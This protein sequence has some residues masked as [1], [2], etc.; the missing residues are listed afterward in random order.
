MNRYTLLLTALMIL[1]LAGFA[2]AGTAEEIN[3]AIAENGYDWVA[4]DNEVAKLNREL[5]W[6]QS[7]TMESV[8]F[9]GMFAP[10]IPIES[11]EGLPPAFDWRNVDGDNFVTSIKNQGSCGSCWA[12]ATTGPMETAIAYAEGWVDPRVDLSEQQLVSCSTAGSCESGGLTTS[13]FRFAEN[14]GIAREECFP[15]KASDNFA[16][17]EICSDWHDQV[18]KIDAWELVSVTGF[19]IDDIKAAVLQA[20]VAGSLVIYEDLFYY[21]SGV[22]QNTKWIPQGLHAVT[23]IGWDDALECWIAKNS[24][25]GS[26]GDNGIF[27]IKWGNSLI[28]SMSIMPT[29]YTQNLGPEPEEGDDDDEP[30]TDDDDDDDAVQEPDSEDNGDD[31]DD[32]DDDD[33]G[34]CG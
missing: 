32:D 24:W 20:P 11:K 4:A 23:I 2:S 16:C 8:D 34:C 29:Y 17:D 28:A 15:Y 22:Y 1:S 19:S 27:K 10:H 30:E 26:W 13:S 31:D 12:F 3:T 7:G 33:G 6:Y 25:G 5:G 18:F 14:S 21:E 9:T